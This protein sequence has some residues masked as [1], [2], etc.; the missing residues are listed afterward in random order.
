MIRKEKKILIVEDNELNLKLFVAVLAQKGYRIVTAT[1]A[2]TGI[3][4][5]REQPPDL[6]LMDLQL[7]GMD[8]FQAVSVLK[9]D[10]RLKHI[11]VVAL[12]GFGEDDV[13]KNSG[14]AL[15]AGFISKPISVRTFPATLAGFMGDD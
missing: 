11:P 4:L 14:L 2:E 15:F 3:R 5:A 9:Q 13:G 12:S 7:P 6:I 8:G 10:D 1:D